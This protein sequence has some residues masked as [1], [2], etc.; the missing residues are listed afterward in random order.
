MWMTRPHV[1]TWAADVVIA[2]AVAAVLLTVGAS[3]DVPSTGT[4]PVGYA[5]LIMGGLALVAR[6]GA[7]VLVLLL[8][9]ACA[10]GYQA[11]G[12]DVPA[13]AFLVAV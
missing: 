10:V 5:L 6:R 2:V 7:P 13:I 12:F 4:A 8:T 11:L 1:P 9:G 3:G